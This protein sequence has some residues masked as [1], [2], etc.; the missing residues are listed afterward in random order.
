MDQ[1]VSM[2]VEADTF[3]AYNNL[4]SE[5]RDLFIRQMDSSSTG[6]QGVVRNLNQKIIEFLPTV[7]IHFVSSFERI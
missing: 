1:E 4:I 3:F 5:C 6:L 2:N 7:A